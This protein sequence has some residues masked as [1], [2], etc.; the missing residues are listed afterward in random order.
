MRAIGEHFTTA[1]LAAANYES[2]VEPGTYSAR[3]EFDQPVAVPTIVQ[4]IGAIVAAKAAQNINWPVSGFIPAIP[5]GAATSVLF[6]CDPDPE[7]NGNPTPAECGI[8][9]PQFVAEYHEIYGPVGFKIEPIAADFRALPGLIEGGYDPQSHE[10]T[11]D[12][13]LAIL[14]ESIRTDSG[15]SV[16]PGTIWS[17]RYQQDQDPYYLE[18][19]LDIRGSQSAAESVLEMAD[20][21]NQHRVVFEFTDRVTQA[22]QRP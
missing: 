18:A 7:R 4:R 14:P 8:I 6:A 12:E 20:R 1:Q 16:V 5:E 22:V 3:M 19:G 15:L 17:A 21:M 11:P 2:W 10:F 13:A 9:V